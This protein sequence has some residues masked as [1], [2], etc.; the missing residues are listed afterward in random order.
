VDAQGAL[1]DA[2][3]SAICADLINKWCD[4]PR[5][6]LYAIFCHHGEPVAQV[7][8]DAATA[9]LTQQWMTASSYDPVS[10]IDAL[11][12][13]LL[14]AFRMSLG[15][16]V[17]F[18]EAT[19]F[20]HVLAGLVMT[21]D[22]MGSDTRFHPLAGSDSRPD[23]AISLL[24]ATRWSGWHSGSEPQAILGKYRPRG[25]QRSL[26]ELPLTEHLVI[27]E[28]PTGSG[29]TEAALIWTDRL[30]AAGLVDGM[31]FAVPTRSA[32][33]ELHDR[34]SKVVGRVHGSLLGRVIRAVP[35]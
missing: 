3:R 30:V 25:V 9:A 23:A 19:R 10:E 1:S 34:I 6:V 17:P 31:Y 20:E 11:T 29:K 16:A 8:I 2:V 12:K 26:L 18:P 13:A 27:V 15:E 14:S 32:A 21:A 24:D 5:G 7:R 4:D 28:A 33:T 22:W 35:G